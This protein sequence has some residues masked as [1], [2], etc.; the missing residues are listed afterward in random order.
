MLGYIMETN[1]GF[2]ILGILLKTTNEGCKRDALVFF[3]S[4]EKPYC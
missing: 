4:C 3:Y 2:M 1:H